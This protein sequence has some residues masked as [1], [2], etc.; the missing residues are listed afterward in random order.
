MN[1]ISS[2]IGWGLLVYM[3]YK[4]VRTMCRNRLVDVGDRAMTLALFFVVVTSAKG[5]DS[6]RCPRWLTSCV[7]PLPPIY[8]PN[9]GN[10]QRAK[11]SVRWSCLRLPC[12]WKEIVS[13]SLKA[14]M[15]A[16]CTHCEPRP[17]QVTL[18]SSTVRFQRSSPCVPC[19]VAPS[20]TPYRPVAQTQVSSLS[21]RTTF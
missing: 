1:D 7:A 21:T 19:T 10:P 6:P 16:S 12:I 14:C 17:A 9:Q 20:D 8:H 11:C 13:H 2:F 4:L 3:A 15:P 18:R 5:V